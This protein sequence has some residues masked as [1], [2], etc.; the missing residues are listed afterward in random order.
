MG[1]KQLLSTNY[2]GHT[3]SI[4]NNYELFID[5][6]L[7]DKDTGLPI[8]IPLLSTSTLRGKIRKMSEDDIS[9]RAELRHTGIGTKVNVYANSRKIASKHCLG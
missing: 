6:T 7:Q 9:I 8:G 2:E 3:I 4:T 1:H 5:D